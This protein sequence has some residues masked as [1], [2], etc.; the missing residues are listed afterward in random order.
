VERPSAARPNDVSWQLTA[1]DNNLGQLVTAT[2]TEADHGPAQCSVL[3]TLNVSRH[4]CRLCTRPPSRAG[5]FR[6]LQLVIHTNAEV[7]A[8][9]TRHVRL[10]V[11]T[12]RRSPPSR[13]AAR[14]EVSL[15]G[16]RAASGSAQ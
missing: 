9:T 10:G 15:A 13:P 2:L 4:T 16:Q 3:V 5:R 1:S 7:A 12:C 14:G 6:H 11:T 8:T